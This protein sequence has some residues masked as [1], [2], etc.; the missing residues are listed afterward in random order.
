MI[1]LFTD[2]MRRNPFA[3]YDAMR[4]ASPAFKVPPPFDAWMIF[5]YEGVKRTLNDHTVFSSSVPAPRNWFIFFDPPKHAKL[6]GLISRAFT[7]RVVSSL[8]PRIRE[9]SDDLLERSVERG[10]MDVALDF[11]VPLPMMVIAEMIGIPRTEWE[12]F[13][14]WSDVIMRLSY[15]RS[16]GAEAAQAGADFNRV[17]MEMNDYLTEMTAERRVERRDDL[18][19]RLTEAEVE[20]EKLTHEEILGFFQLLIVAGQETT[21][22]LINNAV[23]C[24]VEHPEELTRLQTAPDLLPSAIE[25]VLRYRSPIQWMMRTPKKPVEIHGQVIPAGALVL[26]MI[27]SANRDPGQFNDANRFDIARAPNPHLSFGHGIHACIGA[28]LA[29]M[30]T[31]IALSGFLLRLGKFE[32]ASNEPW[33]PRKALHV[34]GPTRLPIRFERKN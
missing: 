22:N 23:V 25:E 3:A 27:G 4:K 1:D 10:E 8:E 5:D 26:P 13:K 7:P 12:R 32:L 15:T 28:A 2:E 9:L 18:L 29:R 17:T 20:G 19:T 33:E 16:G 14:S 31:R 21:T 11:A 30:E 6:R 34:H 24:L